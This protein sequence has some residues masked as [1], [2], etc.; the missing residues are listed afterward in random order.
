VNEGLV[1][2]EAGAAVANERMAILQDRWRSNCWIDVEIVN[3]ILI[4][5]NN[6]SKDAAGTRP[7]MAPNRVQGGGA[8]DG[9]SRHRAPEVALCLNRFHSTRPHLSDGGMM[10]ALSRREE[11]TL[12]KATKTH[13][14]KE[15]DP[16]VKRT[17]NPLICLY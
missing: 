11:D 10:N 3:V 4:P 6:H 12:M 14:L 7:A 1:G 15:C 8:D 5:F 9:V 2:A 17:R 16:L 13:A